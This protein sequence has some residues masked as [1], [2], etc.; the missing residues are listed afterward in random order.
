VIEFN[1]RRR[2]AVT[3]KFSF[4]ALSILFAITLSFSTLG[5]QATAP[6]T[7]SKLLELSVPA[8]SLKGNLLG[9]PTEQ[10]VYVYLPPG[11]EG[12]ATKRY[13]TLYLLHGFTANSSAWVKGGYQGL[14]LQTLMDD[15]IKNG[16]VREMIVVAANGNNAYKGSFYTNSSVT[17]NWEDFI[18]GDLLN[19][20]DKTYRTIARAESRG[21]AGHSMGGYGAVM[22]GMKH[23]ESFSAVYALSPC[24]LAMES[25]MSEANTAWSGVLGL[26][27][28][29][30]INAPPKS[31]A[32]FYYSAFIALSAAFSPNPN[33]AP[34]YVDFPF[35]SKPGICSP[36][37]GG[38]LLTTAPCV[39]KIEPI[40][41][42]WRSKF[43]VYIAESNKQNLTKLHGIFLDYGE[44]E[45][46]AHI[47]QG[48]QLF[49]KALSEL[50]IPHQFEVYADGNHG[51]R[52]RQRMEMR[53]LEFFNE[54]LVFE[55]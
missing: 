26:T 10:P 24:C 15:L 19:H 9:D 3:R 27:S 37:S 32:E 43:P 8:P 54:K 7:A 35:E 44:N 41:L 17:G 23:P 46:F 34:F 48:V 18:V 11:Y 2:I 42:K 22:L 12:S 36:P 31:F 52:I 45:E 30:Q 33:R 6:A 14:N 20:I 13:P 38:T 50:N 47:R 49:S 40:Y 28:R 51:N 21:I 39:Q 55:K 4:A 16:K 1:L 5:Q 53:V 25:D 29:D